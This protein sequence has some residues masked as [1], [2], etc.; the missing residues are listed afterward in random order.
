[1]IIKKNRFSLFLK[2]KMD[3]INIYMEMLNDYLGKD[4]FHTDY[5]VPTPPISPDNSYHHIHI[6]E[7]TKKEIY[8][9]S[10]IFQ[11][12]KY[13]PY[14][15]I[16]HF[17][18]HINRINFSQSVTV[19]KECFELVNQWIDKQD[20][21]I[22]TIFWKNDI[23]ERLRIVLSKKFKS[24]CIEYIPFLINHYRKNTNIFHLT[25]NYSD[26]ARMCNSFKKIE[27]IYVDRHSLYIFNRKRRFIS[28]YVMV[29]C[30]FTLFHSHPSYDLP[31]LKNKAKR[32]FFY[33]YV[34]QL[35]RSDK[36]LRTTLKSYFINRL[37]NCKC[38][39]KK[40]SFFKQCYGMDPE[41]KQ[42]MYKNLF[43]Y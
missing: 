33:N 42:Y 10:S 17:R 9:S 43:Y 38:C 24:R 14:K 29:Q 21:D 32:Y 36:L 3:S 5:F 25:V 6:A 20:G 12:R 8:N 40:S 15:R 37:K 28:Y 27:Q 39:K 41:V 7:P 30:L 31:T 4:Q 26:Y 22:K 11:K 35:I 1:M 34:F 19:P 13:S 18:E 16:S 23:Y 2:V